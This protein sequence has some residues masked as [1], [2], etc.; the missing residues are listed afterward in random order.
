MDAERSYELLECAYR[1]H[2]KLGPGLLESTYETCLVH[3]LIKAGFHVQRQKKL[4]IEY[5]GVLLDAG[6]R[7]DLI[8]DYEVIIEIKAVENLHD[9]HVSQLL[10]YMKL[11]GIKTG[12]LINFNVRSL[13]SGIKRY[14]VD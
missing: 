4:P 2:S 10:T 12:Y 14:I 9:I 5:D 1:V 7:V 11:S 3:E 13:K 8:I 6:Y